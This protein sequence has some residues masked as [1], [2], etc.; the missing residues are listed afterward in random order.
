M[1]RHPHCRLE[2]EYDYGVARYC[3]WLYVRTI[4]RRFCQ[5][6]TARS[7]LVQFYLS[8]NTQTCCVE[9]WIARARTRAPPECLVHQSYS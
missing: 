9:W 7:A 3:R 8:V 6:D 1:R 5:L 2:V 4:F